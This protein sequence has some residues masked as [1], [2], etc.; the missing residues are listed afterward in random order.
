MS[1]SSCEELIRQIKHVTGEIVRA[2]VTMPDTADVSSGIDDV[3]H[4]QELFMQDFRPS[5]DEVE[6][7]ET[8]WLGTDAVYTQWDR[9]EK[10]THRIGNDFLRKL[11]PLLDRKRREIYHWTRRFISDHAANVPD[12]AHFEMGIG[13]AGAE[14][15]EHH[16]RIEGLYESIKR[17]GRLPDV[18][19]NLSIPKDKVNFAIIY[20]GGWNVSTFSV[21]R[22]AANFAEMNAFVAFDHAG[23]ELFGWVNG[24]R[25]RLAPAALLRTDGEDNYVLATL[26]EPAVLHFICPHR[27]TGTA[28]HELA[29]PVLRSDLVLEIVRDKSNTFRAL[30]WYARGRNVDLPL[31]PQCTIA[32]APVRP[33][34]EKLTD[35]IRRG[36]DRLY[37]TAVREI[38]IKPN[39]GEQGQD[40]GYFKLP[41]EFDLAVDHALLLSLE[42][43]AVI[44]QRIRPH[45][46]ID[47]NWR[48]LVALSPTG[49]P[50]VVGRFARK[51]TI[52]RLE[53]VA[54]REMLDQCGMNCTDAEGFLERLNEVS[55]HAFR[56][57]AAYAEHCH[58]NFPWQPLGGPSY[59]TPYFLG[60]DLIGDAYIMEV[61]GNE[62]AGMWT[63]DRLY[64]QTRGRS[65]RTVLQSAQEAA[66]AYKTALE[67]G[68]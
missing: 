14:Y 64:P 24:R 31:I 30:E 8:L 52:D 58:S 20:G 19:E 47:F 44:Q 54:D 18:R 49:R 57:V 1:I 40:V 41:A 21:L 43:G 27:W 61:N 50:E 66:R 32:Q 36:L 33:D 16:E 42:S 35:E 23:P 28:A 13:K 7:W 29:V 51:G 38:V 37:S 60:I 48:T 68:R 67:S 39:V 56:A 26:R 25:V 15:R 6:F 63:D 17:M 34:V 2:M 3:V 65:N 46:T 5:K 45:E 10:V 9:I 22:E 4:L 55:L 62:V 59:T 12:K 53:M 11:K